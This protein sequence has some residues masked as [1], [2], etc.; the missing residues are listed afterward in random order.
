MTFRMTSFTLTLISLEGN[1]EKKQYGPIQKEANTSP[2]KKE[3]RILT[4]TN[5]AFVM[6]EKKC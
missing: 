4:A 2:H 6:L 1:K 3:V 5:I